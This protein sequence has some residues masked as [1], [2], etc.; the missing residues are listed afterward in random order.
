MISP[1]RKSPS[2]PLDLERLLST[3]R[4]AAGPAANRRPEVSIALY[5]V[6]VIAVSEISQL[7]HL[8]NLTLLV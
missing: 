3:A 8:Q 7:C 5:T 6:V 4:T 1:L 2:S